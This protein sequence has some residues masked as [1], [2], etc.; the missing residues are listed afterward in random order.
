M[1]RRLLRALLVLLAVSGLA[2]VKVSA[3][4]KKD[5]K[6]DP[7]STFEPRSK[8]GAGQKFLEKFV[9]DWDVVKTFHPRAGDPVQAKGECRQTMIHE[10]RFLCS[11]FVFQQGDNK[12]TGTGMIG[13]EPETETFTSAW[14]DSRSTRMSLRQS[15]GKFDGKEIVLYSASL[16]DGAKDA[17]RSQTV[18]RLEDEGRKIV[19]RQYNAGTDGK[20]RLIMELVMTRKPSKK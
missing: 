8:P 4:E 10:G 17:R 3:Q 7:Q 1:T 19:H 11:E 15:Q 14:T 18:T 2:G 6:K 16:K 9:G 5:D 13:F 12:T 20:E